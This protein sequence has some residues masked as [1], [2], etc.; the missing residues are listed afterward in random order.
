MSESEFERKVAQLLDRGLDDMKQSTLN[1]L[2]LARRASLEHYQVAEA[3]V[4]VGQGAS[5]HGHDWHFGTRKLLSLI[6]LLFAIASATYWQTLQQGDENEEI[7]I[8][9]LVDELPV[10]AY[11]DNEFD[12]WLDGS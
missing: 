7:D 12:A 6:A 10:N 5:A 4:S 3:L 2:Q 8:M 1:R 9:L 11:L